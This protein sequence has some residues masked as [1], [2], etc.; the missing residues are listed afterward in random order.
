MIQSIKIKNFKVFDSSDNNV[1]YLKKNTLV[2]GENNSGKS[3]ILEAL[4]YFFN[5][6]S[7][8]KTFIPDHNS[9]T[10]ISIM[11]RGKVYYKKFKKGTYKIEES[12]TNIDE[13]KHLSYIYISA[14]PFDIVAKIKEFAVVE[15]KSH[16]DPGFL[17][18][19]KQFAQV[20]IDNVINS[21]DE[22]L[23]IIDP[24]LNNIQSQEKFEISTTTVKYD[25]KYD[26]IEL[27]SHGLG[28]QKTFMY[29]LLTKRQYNNVILGIDEIENS[30]S[31]SNTKNLINKIKEKFDQTIFTTHSTAV[32]KEFKVNDILPIYKGS[33]H[34]NLAELIKNLGDANNPNKKFILVEGKTDVIWINKALELLGLIADYHVIFGGGSQT[35]VMQQY[36][37]SSGFNVVSIGDGDRAVPNL[38][39]YLSKEI[40]EL[41]T[42]FDYLT[43]KYSLPISSNI[44]SKQELINVLSTLPG[45]KSLDTIK[46]ELI[47]DIDDILTSVNHEFVVEIKGILCDL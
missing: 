26:G 45:N 6:E 14:K 47:A 31:L 5:Q 33:S 34:N 12:S 30:L 44:Q 22:Q 25:I 41:Y 27:T 43:H 13:I 21:I 28:S 3:S 15:L 2:I 4:D 7:I 1:F 11:S 18:K 35:P 46:T 23:M 16:I 17:L 40:I 37:I 36:L 24:N 20:A 42:G 29:G 10:I 39:H 9:E 8:E 19:F 32:S 38:N